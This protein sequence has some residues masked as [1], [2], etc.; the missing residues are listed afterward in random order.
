MNRSKMFG[1]ARWVSNKVQWLIFFFLQW[2]Q[3]HEIVLYPH[4]TLHIMYV[5][6]QLVKETTSAMA[7]FLGQWWWKG[8]NEDMEPKCAFDH[9]D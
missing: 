7:V 5:P 9:D 8:G 6:N 3:I 4:Y 1:T 2:T